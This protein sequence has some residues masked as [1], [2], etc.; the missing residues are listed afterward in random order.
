MG[1]GIEGERRARTVLVATA[2]SCRAH[3]PRQGCRRGDRALLAPRR[4]L[5]QARPQHADAREDRAGDAAHQPEHAR[6]I[7]LACW[8]VLLL[9]VHQCEGR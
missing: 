6:G 7:L 3:A 4:T 8:D 2:V 5:P 1:D 9:R